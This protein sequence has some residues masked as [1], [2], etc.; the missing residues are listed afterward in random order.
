ML[1]LFHLSYRKFNMI[2]IRLIIIDEGLSMKKIMK[3]LV[4][5]TAVLLLFSVFVPVNA[6]GKAES[7]EWELGQKWSMGA[8]RDL[9]T[10]LDSSSSMSGFL[11]GG[12]GDMESYSVD[13]TGDM[14]FYQIYEV[15][16]VTEN[17]YTLDIDGGGGVHVE[18][19]FSITG[20]FPEEGNYSLED[21]DYESFEEDI[22]KKEMTMSGDGEFH[23]ILDISGEAH[24]T[25]DSLA[26]NDM[27]LKMS[28]EM[29]GSFEGEN[30]PLDND[31]NFSTK[32]QT[33]ENGTYETQLEG[34][35][36]Y[37]YEDMDMKLNGEMTTTL[38]TAFEPAL[39]MFD[40]PIES[41]EIWTVGSTA[42]ISGTY[43]GSIDA[44]ALPESIEEE[45]EKEE[46]SFP[47]TLDEM[48]TGSEH[49]DDGVIKE[50]TKDVRLSAECRD[51]ENLQLEDGT[52][53]EVYLISY[54]P[55]RERLMYEREGYSTGYE[56]PAF[57]LKYS[58]E[59]EFILSQQLSS[60]SQTSSPLS[61]FTGSDELSMEPMSADRAEKEMESLQAMPKEDDSSSLVD[62]ILR[63]PYVY[64]L[65]GLITAAVVGSVVLA[66][67]EDK[68]AEEVYKTKGE[69]SSSF[70]R[71]DQPVDQKQREDRP[72]G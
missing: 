9:D 63:P 7:P 39:D 19:G 45:I 67:R 62:G 65:I 50:H 57:V 5:S 40:F 41:D 36:K 11:G 15:T 54:T 32:P 42:T 34:Y 60:Y 30:L 61:E 10:H 66:D 59:Q 1:Y 13:I 26:L 71:E 51:T 25:K 3:G 6:A 46:M 58:P 27:D 52:S 2:E 47:L 22:P 18:G 68:E 70:N 17:E 23:L 4:L 20:R 33:I 37:G 29:K 53:T 35:M 56:G 24:F 49:M 28:V 44:Q 64:V 69:S 12:S 55:Q 16:E 21:G 38:Q 8:E 14:G 31:M 72:E 43:E 48:A